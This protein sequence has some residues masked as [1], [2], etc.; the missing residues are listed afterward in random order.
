[1][2]G[3]RLPVAACGTSQVAGAVSGGQQ[4][5][6]RGGQLGSLPDV[7][8]QRQTV[9]VGHA[10]VEAAPTRTAVR[11]RCRARGV[12]GRHGRRPPP[13]ASSASRATTRPR[14]RRL[15][16]LSSTMSTGRCGAGPMAGQPTVLRGVR[17]PPEP[18]GEGEGAP[19]ARLAFSR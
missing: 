12:H 14:M 17:L 4:N 18:R 3:E 5:N 8:G 1:M 19:P 13:Q 15:V 6:A 10:G 2:R 11:R 16:A 7:G 9:R